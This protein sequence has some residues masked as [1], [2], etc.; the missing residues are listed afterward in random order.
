MPRAAV[1]TETSIAH[2]SQ[3]DHSKAKAGNLGR[4]SDA[5]GGRSDR[6]VVFPIIIIIG[7]ACLITSVCLASLTCTF[8]RMPVRKHALAAPLVFMAC[9]PDTLLRR[10]SLHLHG[11]H[12]ARG[13]YYTNSTTSLCSLQMTKSN[14]NLRNPP[15]M[16]DNAPALHDHTCQR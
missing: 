4:Q 5:S 11:N 3:T 9:T 12:L 7:H 1:E 2:C 6:R 15:K 8:L 14:Q 13:H 10:P 16:A